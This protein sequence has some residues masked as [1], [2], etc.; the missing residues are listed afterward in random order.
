MRHDVW[1]RWWRCWLLYRPPD[2]LADDIDHNDSPRRWR[3][4]AEFSRLFAYHPARKLSKRPVRG[5]WHGS[6]LVRGG[7][8]YSRL[9]AVLCATLL[10][11]TFHAVDFFA[12]VG[13]IP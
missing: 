1:L 13:D 11:G 10:Q 2:F 5:G 8:C 3:F 7:Y 9:T 12:E 6:A 4:Q